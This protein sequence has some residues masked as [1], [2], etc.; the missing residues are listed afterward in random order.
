MSLDLTQPI[1]FLTNLLLWIPALFFGFIGMATCL[2]LY[3][4][5]RLLMPDNP[6]I[7]V[8]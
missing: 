1:D 5:L 2:P 3:P 6:Y 4:L 8:L 7:C